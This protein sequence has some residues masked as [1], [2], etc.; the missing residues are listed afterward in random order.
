[1]LGFLDHLF[2]V[3]VGEPARGLDLD[4]LFLAGAL[5]LGTDVDDAVGVD[6][7]RDLDLRH[8]A[9]AAG[10]PTRSNWPRILLSRAIS[11]SPWKTRIVTAF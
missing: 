2:D 3:G 4:L 10:M 9:G 5:V 6:V 7:E 8:A 1:L 11:R